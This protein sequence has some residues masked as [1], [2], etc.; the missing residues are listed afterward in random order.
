MPEAACREDP[1][2]EFFIALGGS[3]APAKAV[4]ARCPVRKACLSYALD[5]HIVHGV[6]GGT[7]ELERRRLRSTRRRTRQPG[8]GRLAG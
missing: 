2:V 4:C 6:C 7:W 1:E 3:T 5:K 8:K